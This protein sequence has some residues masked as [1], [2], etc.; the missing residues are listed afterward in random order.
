MIVVAAGAGVIAPRGLFVGSNASIL[1]G[2]P[3]AEA[4]AGDFCLDTPPSVDI[5]GIVMLAGGA[6]RFLCES[7]TIPPQLSWILG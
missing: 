6:L 5:V 3:T 7:P 1:A 2:V 4:D